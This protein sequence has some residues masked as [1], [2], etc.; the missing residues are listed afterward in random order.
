MSE[1]LSD[2][3][4][5]LYWI[6]FWQFRKWLCSC[7]LSPIRTLVIFLQA[8]LSVP[9]SLNPLYFDSNESNYGFFSLSE[10]LLLFCCCLLQ[11]LHFFS[12][13][14]SR[15]LLLLLTG[16]KQGSGFSFV[17]LF[18]PKSWLLL[19]KLKVTFSSISHFMLKIK[20]LGDL[21][22]I[23]I[24]TFFFICS[25]CRFCIWEF[26]KLAFNVNIQVLPIN[27]KAGVT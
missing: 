23:L 8:I 9:I 4:N 26:A 18:D 7:Y 11:G 15:V 22:L 6:S 21:L 16:W 2:W 17:H 12:F 24:S 13:A 3:L 5:C 25:F 10:R 19:S 20:S 1:F 27:K 14:V